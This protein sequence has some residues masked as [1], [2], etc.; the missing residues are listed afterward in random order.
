MRPSLGI[1]AVAAYCLGV[2]WVGLF[3]LVTVSTG[4]A[5]VRGTFVSENA[6]PRRR[7]PAA[8][9]S[10]H[11]DVPDRMWRRFQ[12]AGL[13]TAGKDPAA[14]DP[15]LAP[16]PA[17]GTPSPSAACV[18]G[19]CGGG[20]SWR[21]RAAEWFLSGMRD[22]GAGAGYVHRAC[23]G[24]HPPWDCGEQGALPPPVG[25]GWGLRWWVC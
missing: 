13:G 6:L 14:A 15:G 16:L 19:V 25:T 18:A 8:V 21:R 9:G 17:A 11:L 7:T 1:L 2:V 3:P 23:P 5:K 20:P 12:E 22:A 4:E 10:Q 24:T